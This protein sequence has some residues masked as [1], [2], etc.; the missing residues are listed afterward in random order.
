MNRNALYL[1][2]CLLVAGGAVMGYQLYIERQKTDR[3]E[4]DFGKNGLSMERT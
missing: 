4:I 2:I 1:V 3:V